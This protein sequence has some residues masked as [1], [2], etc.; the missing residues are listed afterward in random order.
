MSR[1]DP[2]DPLNQVRDVYS[3][4]SDSRGSKE[5]DNAGPATEEIGEII[6]MVRDSVTPDASFGAKVRAM[7]VILQISDEVLEGDNSTLGS[8]IRKSFYMLPI[9]SSVTRIFDMLLP[10]E[11]GALQADGALADEMIAARGLAEE[12]A[13]ELELDDVIDQI[14]M[15]DYMSEDE[16]EEDDEGNE[17]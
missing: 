7:S 12:Y 10:E 1:Y 17:R 9:G 8:E 6:A 13:I 16:E 4:Y 3:H 2:E 15:E 14:A 5:H 11:L